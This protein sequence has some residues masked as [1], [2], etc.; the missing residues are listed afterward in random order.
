MLISDIAIAQFKSKASSAGIVNVMFGFE[1]DFAIIIEDH[2]GTNPLFRYWANNA[3]FS[4]WALLLGLLHTGSSGI[5]TRDTSSIGLYAGGDRITYD[6]A[7]QRYLNGVDT[8]EAGPETGDSDP[9]HVSMVGLPVGEADTV[10]Q[11]PF[12][13]QAGLA[14]P[15]DHQVASGYNLVIAFRGNR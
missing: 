11:I 5:M 15:A 3:S 14:I 13:T 1:P 9:K 7:N 4:Q 2:G 6:A 12:T 10:N 8:S